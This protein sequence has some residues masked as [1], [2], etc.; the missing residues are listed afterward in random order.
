MSTPTILVAEDEFIIAC[1]LC[2]TVEEAGY[3]VEG[4]H[5][6]ISSAMLAFQKQRPDVAIL[7]IHLGDEIVYPLAERLMAEDVPV[8]FHSGRCTPAEVR[9]L[10]PSASTLAKPCPP[11][12]V[13][14][15]VSNALAAA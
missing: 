10:Y 1:D 14:Q 9:E 2:D 12:E 5:C 3:F 8:I 7:D 13:L 4:P 11:N 6:N 15:S